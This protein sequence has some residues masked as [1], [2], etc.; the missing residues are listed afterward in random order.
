MKQKVIWLLYIE[1][2]SFTN[3]VGRFYFNP[4]KTYGSGQAYYDLN[5]RIYN[6]RTS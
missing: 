4:V 3:I 5:L 6:S 1:I 2:L